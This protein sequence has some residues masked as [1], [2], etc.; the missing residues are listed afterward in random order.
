MKA[1]GTDRRKISPHRV[2]DAV[3]VSPDGR[4]FVA[5]SPRPDQEHTAQVTA[6]AVDGSTS[7]TLCVSYCS[8]TWDT[9][10]KICVLLLFTGARGELLAARA[11]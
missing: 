9:I 8:L 6:F 10:R 2:L 11:A 4:W 5:G 3:A 7:A 1:D